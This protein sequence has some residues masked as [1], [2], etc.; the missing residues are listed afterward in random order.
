[1]SKQ[2]CQ[3]ETSS[4]DFVLWMEYLEGKINAFHR[5]DYF[6]AQIAAEIRRSFVK[7]PKKVKLDDFLLKFKDKTK[8]ARKKMT[9]E[10]RTK[11]AK[12]FWSALTSLS[13]KPKRKRE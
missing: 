6:L 7:N 8:T 4:T 5:E 12:S 2:R 10:E 3:E 1:M 13:F 9:K 11:I